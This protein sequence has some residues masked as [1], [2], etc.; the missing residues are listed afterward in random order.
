M[1]DL[2][3]RVPIPAKY[4]WWRLWTVVVFVAICVVKRFSPLVMFGS[5]LLCGVCVMTTVWRYDRERYT[6][7][8][9]LAQAQKSAL[10][11]YVMKKMKEE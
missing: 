10:I 8:L 11:A 7:S 6:F 1:K 9:R 5:G 4:Q 2:T 3:T